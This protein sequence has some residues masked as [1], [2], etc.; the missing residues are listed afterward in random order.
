VKIGEKYQVKSSEFLAIYAK[1]L[2][3]HIFFYFLSY[4]SNMGLKNNKKVPH[5]AA[6]KNTFF[7][8]KIE[9]SL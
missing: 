1:T 2:S 5:C 9:S 7:F 6:A 3:N 4:N 8:S